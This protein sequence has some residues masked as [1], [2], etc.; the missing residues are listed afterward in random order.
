MEENLA[1]LLAVVAM[2]GVFTLPLVELV[3]NQGLPTRY[4]PVASVACGL[5]IVTLLVGAGVVSLGIW[6]IIFTGLLAGMSAAGVYSGGKALV[7][8]D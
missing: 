1:G 5:V 7:R 4:A 2:A 8:R 6:A 3:K